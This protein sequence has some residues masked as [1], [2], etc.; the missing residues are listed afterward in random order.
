V[1]PGTYKASEY[2]LDNFKFCGN[3]LLM[4]IGIEEKK[5][6]DM[7]GKELK[8]L[9]KDTLLE[10]IDP[11]HGLEL[12]PSVEKSLKESIDEKKEGKGITL[13]EAKEE[14]GIA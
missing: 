2:P 13:E 4:N 12:W 11:D 3:I 14:L 10:I 8:E 1:T 5:L 7:T 9:I 6:S